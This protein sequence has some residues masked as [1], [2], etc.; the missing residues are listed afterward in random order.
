[1]KIIVTLFWTLTIG[2][3]V[4]YIMTALMGF[5][6]NTIWT[7]IISVFFAIFVLV[8]NAIAIPKD[9]KN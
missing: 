5:P 3:V 7:A 1:M 8:F 4:G 2:Q 9:V 6:D